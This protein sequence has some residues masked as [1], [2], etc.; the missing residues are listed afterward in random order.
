MDSIFGAAPSYIKLTLYL[1]L[2][3][4]MANANK[5]TSLL[6]K[7]SRIDMEARAWRHTPFILELSNP[8]YRI[9]GQVFLVD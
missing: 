8:I 5:R 1:S 9:M 4:D 6:L 2:G 3:K 7:L